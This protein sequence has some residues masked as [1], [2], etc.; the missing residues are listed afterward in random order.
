M[1]YFRMLKQGAF[2]VSLIGKLVRNR[3]R[4]S[5]DLDSAVGQ[6]SCEIA[7]PVH[8]RPRFLGEGVRSECARRV[9]GFP[10]ISSGKSR[11]PQTQ[12]T[13]HA[14]R[15]K[16]RVRRH[17]VRL[18]LAQTDGAQP[19]HCGPRTCRERE[20]LVVLPMRRGGGAEQALVCSHYAFGNAR[21]VVAIGDACEVKR[22]YVNAWTTIATGREEIVENDHL[23]PRRGLDVY[24]RRQDLQQCLAIIYCCA[25]QQH[26][27]VA[28]FDQMREPRQRTCWIEE[29]VTSTG[30]QNS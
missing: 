9:R 12:V 17:D 21:F 5:D 18:S 20:A 7:R 22:A 28:V 2:D 27:H 14:H 26:R 11:S 1:R 25:Q 30:F 8:A 4:S 16:L 23:E 29:H 19:G 10:E 13:Y 6:T 24:R 3:R 15:R